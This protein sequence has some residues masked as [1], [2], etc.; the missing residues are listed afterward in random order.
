MLRPFSSPP[1]PGQGGKNY[2]R[3]E[4]R[5]REKKKKETQTKKRFSLILKVTFLLLALWEKPSGGPGLVHGEREGLLLS[6]P[7]PSRP[8]LPAPP[9]GVTPLGSVRPRGPWTPAGAPVCSSDHQPLGKG[10]FSKKVCPIQAARRDPPSSFPLPKATQ[11]DPQR[12]TGEGQGG[13]SCRDERMGG[14]QAGD[15][16]GPSQLGSRSLLPCGGL[17]QVGVGSGR[18]QSPSLLGSRGDNTASPA[19]A[20]ACALLCLL[21]PLALGDGIALWS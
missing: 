9:G 13:R 2:Y 17:G 16:A 11:R 19:P 18:V 14:Q 5:L 1:S 15:T 12:H 10:P 20:P 8:V 3:C 6:L 7:V 21:A 4:K